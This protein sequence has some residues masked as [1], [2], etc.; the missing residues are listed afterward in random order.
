[1]GSSDPTPKPC[2]WSLLR[3]DKE[4]IQEQALSGLHAG[5]EQ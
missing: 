4:E 1:M 3:A 5:H 2:L